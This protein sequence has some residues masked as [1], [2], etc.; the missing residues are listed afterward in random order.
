[1]KVKGKFL[2][3]L[4]EH[5][6]VI[7]I[8][9]LLTVIVFYKIFILGFDKYIIGDYGD[10]WHFIWNIWWIKEKVILEGNFSRLFYTDYLFYP[11][12]A[13]LVFH[14][15]SPLNGFVAFPLTH[16]LNLIAT[17]NCLVLISFV[18]SG[19]FGY[20]LTNYFT[21]NKFLSFLSGMFITFSS[22]HTGKALGYFNLLKI[23]YLIL[24]IYFY[25]RFLREKKL[26][27]IIISGLLLGMVGLSDFHYLYFSFI[28][29]SF[30]AIYFSLTKV[31]EKEKFLSIS[32]FL[33]HNFM[34]IAIASLITSPWL[35]PMYREYITSD[36]M[37]KY[38]EFRTTIFTNFFLP[39]P[40]SL[41]YS[42]S[43]FFEEKYKET[44]IFWYVESPVGIGILTLP[45]AIA[46]LIFL[47]FKKGEFNFSFLFFMFLISI[48]GMLFSI[49]E[50]INNLLPFY[51]LVGSPTR[52]SVLFAIFLPVFIF[53]TISNFKNK[54]VKLL[55]TS[56]LVT[57]FLLFTFPV[58]YSN[59]PYSYYT[60]EIPNVLYQIKTK[61]G[62]FT[63][64]NLPSSVNLHGM[65]YQTIHEKKIIDGYVSR[66]PL[67]S[68]ST[69]RNMEEA[70]ITKNFDKFEEIAKEVKLKYIIVHLYDHERSYFNLLKNLT[71][72]K[73]YSGKNVEIYEIFTN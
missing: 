53:Y 31:L 50:K 30:S 39:S 32:G 27:W 52:F 21:Q 60:L 4:L 25:F 6:I 3:A 57:D 55:L 63:I 19:Y 38:G 13:T 16:I 7:E 45:F 14:T 44:P 73:I 29:I 62:N 34:I 48:M 72:E 18:L 64:L 49:G 15:L 26:K 1:M 69:V 10:G 59:Y 9:T 70:A 46:I 35:V 68:I 67:T 66:I 17:Y 51:S 47:T 33:F 23:E 37:K 28:F 56:L 22:Y 58:N 61:E 36:W 65:F 24:F 41:G 71:L 54:T 12:G 42:F 40:F 2:N 8:Y 11:H 43:S 20:L 5:V